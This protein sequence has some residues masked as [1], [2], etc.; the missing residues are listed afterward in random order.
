MH[1]SSRD[2]ALKLYAMLSLQTNINHPTE[3]FI[4]CDLTFKSSP[5]GNTTGME[6][7]F[8]MGI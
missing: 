8:S 5:Q 6:G 2:H 1:I 7:L 3:P 4:L